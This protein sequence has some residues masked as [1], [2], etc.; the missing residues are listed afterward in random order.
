MSKT[1]PISLWG[2][3][4]S[5]MAVALLLLLLSCSKEVEELTTPVQVSFIPWNPTEEEGEPATKAS[6][7]SSLDATGFYASAVKG[8]PGADQNAWSNISFSKSGSDFK[9]GKY[10]PL[11]NPSY[12]FYASNR[13]LSYA[14]GGPTISADNSLDVVCAYKSNP[15]YGARNTLQFDHIFARISTVTVNATSPYTISGITVWIVNPKTGG[16]YNLYTGNGRTDGTG[17]S[18]LTPAAASN[19]QLYSNAG[20]ISAG[21]SNT[22]SNNDLWLVPGTYQLIAT[23]TAGVG[24]YIETYTTK[25][26]TANISVQGG[27]VNSISCALSGDATGITFSVGVT[28]WGSANKTA[29]F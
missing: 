4:W 2:A 16:T 28:S 11:T 20:S 18:S 23:W 21:G 14:A 6:V 8:S 9:G 24:D 3:A 25:T 7:T 1:R 26:S 22:G 27:K 19:T 13:P 29:S 12:R 15:T 10:W 17:W 5:L